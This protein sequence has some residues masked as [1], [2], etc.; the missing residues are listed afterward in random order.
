MAEDALNP[1]HLFGHVQDA[2]YFD[3]PRK[4][5]PDGHGHIYL[6]QPLA[7][8]LT[9]ADG[10][11]VLDAHGHPRYEPVWRA[12]TSSPLVNQIIQPLD[13]VLTKF[14]V[15]EVV[16]AL[17]MCVLFMGLAFRIRHGGTPKGRLWNM[18]EAFLIYLRDFV[19]VP[20]IGS[21]DAHKFGPLVWTVFFFVLG[22][23]LMG[24]LPWAG[25]PTASFAVT[26]ALAFVVF[27]TVI[28]SGMARLGVWG[29]WKAQVPHMDLPKPVAILLVPMIFCI[30]IFGLLVKHFVLAVRLLANMIGGHV[31]L[32]VLLAFITAT[33]SSLM[34]WGVMPASVLGAT[35]L[36]LLEL[37]VAFI[38]A[39]I[40]AFLTALFIGMAVHPH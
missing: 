20:S 27:L 19:S 31:V 28:G 15:L 9:D 7:K 23:N 26:A 3:V 25:S 17:I 38:Q 18:L 1:S 37:L 29:F 2:P 35:A 14:M 10:K 6:P 40:F 30:E 36:S 16:V 4:L 33:A 11:P 5:S 8:P 12:Q 21:H 22:C 39:Y 34:F 13:F 24:M 32:A